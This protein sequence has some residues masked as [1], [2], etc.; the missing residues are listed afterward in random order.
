MKKLLLTIGLLSTLSSSAF[1]A[2]PGLRYPHSWG[3]E[4]P[5]WLLPETVEAEAKAECY[6]MA[7][8]NNLIRSSMSFG[9]QRLPWVEVENVQVVQ[10]TPKFSGNNIVSVYH[11][12]SSVC[13]VYSGW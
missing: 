4:Y 6:D 2:A 11:H 12:V 9:A 7:R 10:K 3:A 1:S 5:T 13:V 8:A